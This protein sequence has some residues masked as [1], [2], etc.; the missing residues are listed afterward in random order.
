[1][2]SP[3]TELTIRSMTIEELERSSHLLG[4]VSG[5]LLLNMFVQKFNSLQV[6]LDDA[7][8][9][10]DSHADEL[11]EAQDALEYAE[12]DLAIA[13]SKVTELEDQISTM[14]SEL[15]EANDKLYHADREI[16][17]LEAQITDLENQLATAISRQDWH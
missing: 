12:R 10:M 1:M 7:I 14:A 15:M 6:D 13:E 16:V 3:L 9:A 11:A 2:T 5:E 8:G 17:N 4:N